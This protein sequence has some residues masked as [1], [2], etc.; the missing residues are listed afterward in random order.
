MFRLSG[1]DAAV[2]LGALT[3]IE[4]FA[5]GRLQSVDESQ[6]RLGELI[7]HDRLAP[8]GALVACAAAGSLGCG[9]SAVIVT[10]IHS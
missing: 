5:K 7:A 9:L 8:A 1:D 6:A 4:R 2:A 3:Q 10:F